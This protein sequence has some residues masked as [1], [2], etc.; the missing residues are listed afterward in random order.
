MKAAEALRDQAKTVRE[1]RQA[2]AVLL[3][4]QCGLSLEKTAEALGYSRDATCRLR[5]EFFARQEGRYAEQPSAAKIARQERWARQSQVLDEVLSEAAQGGEVIVPPLKP[6]VEAKLGRSLCLA[7]LYN[8]LA[9]HGWRKLVPDT[10][11]PK[12]DPLAR[13]AWKKNAPATWRIST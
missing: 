5:N 2:L 11:H 3:P 4:L 12:G 1:L 13:D 9:R 10:R 7:T 6:L 8:M